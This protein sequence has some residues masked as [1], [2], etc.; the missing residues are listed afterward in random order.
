[1]AKPIFIVGTNR[2]GTTWLGNLLASHPSV[3]VIQ[4]EEH[5]GIHESAY[6]SHVYNRYGDLSDRV[7]YLEFVEA[8][9]A[10][11]YF[12]LSGVSKR[13]LYELFPANYAEVFRHVMDSF[14][15]SQNKSCWIEKSPRHTLELDL[16][17]KL[18]PDALFI[19]THRSLKDVV[20]SSLGLQIKYS[21]LLVDNTKKRKI[22]II[23]T[24]KS[25]YLKNK[26][27]ETFKK[28]HPNKILISSYESLL[29]EKQIV[30]NKIFDFLDLTPLEVDSNFAKNT[31]FKKS[32][33]QQ[34]DFFTSSEK[35]LINR[36]S[37]ILSKL[38]LTYFNFRLKLIKKIRSRFRICQNP[39]LP[40]WFYRLHEFNKDL[41]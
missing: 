34:D 8:I 13:E 2:S 41:N 1:M 5:H 10:S 38:P 32:K 19:A 37:F 3:A 17:S 27:I 33:E 24:I 4:H 22:A 31:S 39:K 14:A 25:Y 16:I 21:P 28:A 9:G 20:K 35:R 29:K 23:Q 12:K 30:M 18:Y 6:F 7:N 36:Y 15:D 11:D 40:V 26:T